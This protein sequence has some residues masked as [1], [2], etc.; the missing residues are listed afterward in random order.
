MIDLN[1]II[2]SGGNLKLR[3]QEMTIPQH[4]YASSIGDLNS[5]KLDNGH[6]DLKP[7]KKLLPKVCLLNGWT[8]V[9]FPR[10]DITDVTHVPRGRGEFRP[11]FTYSDITGSFSGGIFPFNKSSKSGKL[12]FSDEAEKGMRLEYPTFIFK[13]DDSLYFPLKL[14]YFKTEPIGGHESQNLVELALSFA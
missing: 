2:K 14:L 6:Y 4:Y 12:R 3:L 10:L 1:E 8:F 7:T 5:A 9:S 11:I 13:P